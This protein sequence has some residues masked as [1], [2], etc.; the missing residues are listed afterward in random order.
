MTVEPRRT[1]GVLLV[2]R[3]VPR[4]LVERVAR[5]FARRARRPRG[6][7]A[8]GGPGRR[9]RDRRRRYRRATR[10]AS[11]A[12]FALHGY[13]A[14]RPRITTRATDDPTR[15]IVLVDVVAG[16]AA[17][18]DERGTSTCSAGPRDKSSPWRLGV[19]GQARR[20]GRRSPPSTRPTPPRAGAPHE[21][22][23]TAPGV[24]HDFVWVGAAGPGQ[25]VVLRVRIDAGPL[26]VAAVRGQRPLRRGRARRPRSASTPRPTARSSHLADKLRAFY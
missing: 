20:P 15:T 18:I 2:V 8:R 19:R 10:R 7:P 1:G 17:L 25:R 3:V 24:T 22:L 14:A 21:G 4:K 16:A 5:R 13:P 23:G 9:R 11:S 6:D 12:L 26:Q